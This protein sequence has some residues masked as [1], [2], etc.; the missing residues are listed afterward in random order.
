[1]WPATL[2]SLLILSLF[3]WFLH[4]FLN[5]PF[6][7]QLRMHRHNF[8]WVALPLASTAL[9][10]LSMTI[11]PGRFSSFLR[12]P[13]ILRV[14][15]AA[16]A[17]VAIGALTKLALLPLVYLFILITGVVLC[18][19]LG[20]S[21]LCTKLLQKTDAQSGVKKPDSNQEFA[22]K[23]LRLEFTHSVL[24]A[25]YTA[26]IIAF[27][28]CPAGPGDW[29]GSWL[30]SSAH[31]AHMLF[32]PEE[33][34][35]DGKIAT[36]PG[37]DGA[38]LSPVSGPVEGPDVARK[39][40]RDAAD[41]ALTMK[42]VVSL[43][44]LVVSFPAV[45]KVILALTVFVQRL[46]LKPEAARVS[47]ALVD[48][49]RIRW[50]RIVLQEEHP[51]LTNAAR[52]FWWLLACYLLVFL[53][54]AL[55]PGK[56]GMGIINWLDASLIDAGFDKLSLLSMPNLRTFVAALIA[57]YAAVPLAVTS[58]VFLP[59]RKPKELSFCSEALLV[60]SG[61]RRLRAWADVRQV[62]ITG[63]AGSRRLRIKFRSGG[64]FS[65]AIAGMA[66]S[67]L[68][69]LLTA[70][71]EYA[72][73]CIF[74]EDVLAF[75]QELGKH[76]AKNADK[77]GNPR[78][79]KKHSSTIFVPLRSG[80]QVGE[81]KIRIVR[82]LSSRSLTATY[83]VRLDRRLAILKQFVLPADNELMKT[84]KSRFIREYE[85]LK[86]LEHPR[87]A[88]VLDVFD[89]GDST[90]L[91]LEHANGQDLD[92]LVRDLGQRSESAV[93]EWAGQLCGILE[94][95]HNREPAI[96]HRDL[97]PDN[98]VLCDDGQVR[99]IDF[100]AAQQFVEGVTGTLIGKQCYVAPEQLRGQASRRSD[101]YSLGG[102]MHF[103]LTGREPLPLSACS[104]LEFAK[105]SPWLD[106]L[107]KACTAFEEDARPQSVEE[108]MKILEARGS[109]KPP[110]PEPVPSALSA[111]R[112]VQQES[113][114]D[115][116][117][118]GEAE[119]IQLGKREMEEEIIIRHEK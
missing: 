119:T 112:D 2:F 103:L 65:R 88:R 51:F 97:T 1:L 102:T 85:L 63:K 93:V 24:V 23:M 95:L 54:I 55:A 90:F 27:M 86:A 106:E 66:E 109:L 116:A 115:L 41:F 77:L 5:V 37:N 42:V 47:E 29:I 18:S 21:T 44:L 100:G 15:S 71:D 16:L 61:V 46:S 49:W 73:D 17:L 11:F 98:I 111:F 92:S 87:I 76:D 40:L 70:I 30:T 84:R 96:V 78:E 4:W 82:Q 83:L 28:F 105:V 48:A 9:I 114:G 33:F 99:I 57:M 19:C 43:F 31:N 94:H 45:H 14:L 64:S 22:L 34:G 101:I 52:S 118:S 108:V 72:D 35:T 107:V 58:C 39:D 89:E 79:S 68:N 13:L 117:S 91:L 26:A 56:L 8:G 38:E 80:Q 32:Y 3:C 7:S 59:Q 67:D 53:G 6:F 69:V 75:R 12:R 110:L 36:I 74:S 104:P 10:I 25:A 50:K 81:G 20:V 62:E 60:P 113:S